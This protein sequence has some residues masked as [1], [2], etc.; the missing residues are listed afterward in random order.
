MEYHKS[1]RDKI[2]TLI[3]NEG[4]TPWTEILSEER[5]VSELDKKLSEEVA[6]YLESRELER[7]GTRHFD[8]LKR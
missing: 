4:Y 3:E 6:E 2:P 1:V 5:Y 7:G 8:D